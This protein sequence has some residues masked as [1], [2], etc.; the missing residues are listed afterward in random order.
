MTD[1]HRLSACLTECVER[2]SLSMGIT[3]DLGVKEKV[4]EEK[5]K[6]R[7]YRICMELVL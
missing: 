3:A 5:E 2:N 6:G 7:T 4:K 1:F